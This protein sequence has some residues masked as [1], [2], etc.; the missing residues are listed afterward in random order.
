MT[1]IEK[2]LVK[3]IKIPSFSGS[4]GKI[5]NFIVSQLR[6][7]KIRK[8]IVDGKRF[9]IIARKGNSRK[10]F[11]AHMDTVA[12]NIP[13]KID[14]QNIFGR[15]ACDNKQS[16][17]A[18][19]IVGNQLTDINL[20]FTVGEEFDFAGAKKAKRSGIIGKKDSAIIQEPTNF[21]I[22]TGQRGVI[23][24]TVQTAGKAAH[25]SVDKQNSAIQKLISMLYF[26][27]KKKWT[28]FNVGLIS[29]GIA[30]NIVS[31]RAEAT[32]V[33]RPDNISEY[34]RINRELRRLDAKVIIKNDF[35]PIINDAMPFP[36]KIGKGFSEIAFFK[37]SIKFGAG[38]IK[39]A[40]SDNEQISRT[41]LNILLE[42]LIDLIQSI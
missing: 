11:V 26:L 1:T 25:S 34:D 13:L 19:I 38:N 41:D 32:I 10:W 8:Q 2:L 31:D 33:V 39:F 20:L 6:G 18:S 28:A 17:A 27:E 16:I 40:H 14:S 42:R 24:F 7:F 30:G 4:E 29:G 37:N 9:N 22:I 21:E 35:K 3:L 5:G 12:G 36:V 15:G 23:T